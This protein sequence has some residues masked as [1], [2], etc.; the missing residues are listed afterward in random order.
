MRRLNFL[1]KLYAMNKIS[2]NPSLPERGMIDEYLSPFH[3][4]KEN[5]KITYPPPLEK[6]TRKSIYPPIG[7]GHTT[8]Y[9][10]SPIGKGDNESPNLPL[11]KR[12]IEGDFLISKKFRGDLKHH[13]EKFYA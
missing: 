10:S 9:L 7:K 1:R 8:E 3:F 5:I 13:Y 4:K 12:G 6:E 2:P 11:W